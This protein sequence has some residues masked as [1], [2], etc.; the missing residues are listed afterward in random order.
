MKSPFKKILSVTLAAMLAASAS[1]IAVSAE[2][3]DVDI[4][5]R[6][7]G[8]GELPASLTFDDS[9]QIPTITIL[10]GETKGQACMMWNSAL[11]GDDANRPVNLNETPYLCWDIAGS[12]NWG[13]HLRWGNGGGEDECLR[14]H[15]AEGHENDGFAPSKGSIN[16]KELIDS[17]NGTYYRE[18]DIIPMTALVFDAFGEAGQSITVNKFYFSAT[19]LQQGDNPTQAPGDDS[20]TKAPDNTTT[21]SPDAT[22]AAPATT[23]KNNPSTGE[24]SQTV[25]AAVVLAASAAAALFVVKKKNG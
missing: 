13:V 7:D 18:D 14:Y 24:A 1:A 21:K 2:P 25:A 22:T 17:S 5:F 19:P 8:F 15:I 3:A 6:A 16:L 20:T 12:A 23:K 11:L 10:E 9:E 4:N